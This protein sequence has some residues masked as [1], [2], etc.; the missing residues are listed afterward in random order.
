MK[1]KFAGL[2]SGA[3][4]LLTSALAFAGSS[5]NAPGGDSGGGGSEPEMFALILFSLIP[6]IFFIRKARAMQAIRS[7]ER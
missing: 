1:R 5:G 4:V 2:V 6:G 3:M 7:E